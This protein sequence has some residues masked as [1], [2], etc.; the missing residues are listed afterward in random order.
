MLSNDY[1]F[2]EESILPNIN[3]E[4]SYGVKFIIVGDSSV[5]KSSILVRFTSSKFDEKHS[6]TLSM[7]FGSKH[8]IYNNSD[9]LVQIWD[10]AG[11]EQ[12]KSITR[13]YY[14]ES[15]VA[16]MV[17]D[18]R[19]EESF[20]HIKVWLEDCKNLTPSSTLLVLIGNKNDLEEERKITKEMG[21]NFANENNMIF[22]ETSALNGS[23]VDNA[24]QKC[25]E[26]IDRRI[27]EGFYDLNEISR[28]GIKIMKNNGVDSV[29]DNIVDKKALAEGAKKKK[30]INCCI[31]N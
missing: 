2:E 5:G 19:K 6:P 21:E 3:V 31:F 24:F 10:T 1:E 8:I 27:K 4:K 12:Y 9:Y 25:I 18:I 14:K 17:Y 28:S 20:E 22:F 13:S 16:M 11:Q 15:A 23:G 29:S 26:N 30:S 7:E